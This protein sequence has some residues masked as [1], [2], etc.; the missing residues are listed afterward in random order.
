MTNLILLNLI[1][2]VPRGGVPLPGE[3][4]RQKYEREDQ[5]M[6]KVGPRSNSAQVYPLENLGG[7]NVKV[8][9]NPSSNFGN[10][11]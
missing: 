7:K 11:Q 2:G 9:F 10:F 4:R 5:G 1:H 3:F 6:T 8:K